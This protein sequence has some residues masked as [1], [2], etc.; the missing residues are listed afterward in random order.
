[1]YQS[2]LIQYA[3]R[4]STSISRKRCFVSEIKKGFGSGK[5]LGL[6]FVIGAF[7]ILAVGFGLG[8]FTFIAELSVLRLKK[9]MQKVKQIKER[10]T[11]NKR[12]NA[13]QVTK[14]EKVRDSNSIGDNDGCSISGNDDGATVLR[15]R[16]LSKVQSEDGSITVTPITDEINTVENNEC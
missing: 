1:M 3:M 9:I 10:K 7:F 6:D 16:V 5:P 2:G 15:E 4:S 11:A 12:P 8:F 14:Q 13:I